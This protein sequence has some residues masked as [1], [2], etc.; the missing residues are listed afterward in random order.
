[1]K[2]PLRLIENKIQEARR[3]KEI[4]F[5]RKNSVRAQRAIINATEKFARISKQT[6]PI[7][8]PKTFATHS[9]YPIR[10]IRKKLNK[11]SIEGRINDTNNNCSAKPQ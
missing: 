8:A 10:S 1:M 7:L 2:E 3:K 5:A 9:R 4:L 6:D 11:M